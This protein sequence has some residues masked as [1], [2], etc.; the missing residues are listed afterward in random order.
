MALVV[1]DVAQDVEMAVIM[2][3]LVDVQKYVDLVV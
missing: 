1:K 3:A 2:D